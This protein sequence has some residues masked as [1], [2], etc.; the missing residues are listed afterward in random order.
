Q[1]RHRRQRNRNRNR[2]QHG[3]HGR[4]DLM[5]RTTSIVRTAL[6]LG[7]AALAGAGCKPHYDGLQVRFLFGDGRSAPDRLEILEGKATIIE[8]QP[9]SDNPYEDYESFDLVELESYDEGVLFVAPAPEP[10]QFVVA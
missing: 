5:A 2:R 3:Q 8:V 1:R 7:I 4:S 6:L 10:D 9:I